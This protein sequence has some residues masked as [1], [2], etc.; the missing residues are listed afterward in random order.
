M[1]NHTQPTPAEPQPSANMTF[2]ALIKEHN[3]IVSLTTENI[4]LRERLEKL[5]EYAMGL[6]NALRERMADEAKGEAGP[7]TGQENA[8]VV[9][10]A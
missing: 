10:E 7:E 6:E 1:S 2:E 4:Q 8:A 5:T 9:D 3:V